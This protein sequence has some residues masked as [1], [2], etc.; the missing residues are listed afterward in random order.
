MK[1]SLVIIVGDHAFPLGEHG[2]YSL[3]SGYHE[4]SFRVPFFIVWNDVLA[5]TQLSR[6]SSQLDIA[7][8]ILDLMAIPQP[9][10]MT[11]KSLISQNNSF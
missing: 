8:T 5:P 7:P 9:E 11:G 6:A 2:N 1:D 10:E 4:E 3:E